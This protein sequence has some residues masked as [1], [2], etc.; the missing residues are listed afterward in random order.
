M[1]YELIDV[2]EIN[3]IFL[4]LNP[5]FIQKYTQTAM[6][7]LELVIQTVVFTTSLYKE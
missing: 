3:E 4:L 1:F 5:L 2:Y 7:C 6:M